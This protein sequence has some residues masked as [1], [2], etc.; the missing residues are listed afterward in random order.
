M[1]E[2]IE[3]FNQMLMDIDRKRIPVGLYHGEMGLCIYFY[4]VA[5]LTSEKKY[6]DFADRLLDDVIN[7]VDENSAIEIENGLTGICMGINYLL[8]KGYTKGNP[9]HVLKNFDDKI[10]KTLLFNLIYEK[11]MTLPAIHILTG[12]LIYLAVRLQNIKLSKDERWIM[13]NLIIENINKIE[14]CEIEKFTEPVFFSLADYFTPLYLRLLQQISQLHF[15]D[16]KIEKIVEGLS[17]PLLYRYPL[18]KANRLLL[19]SAMNDVAATFSGI[20]GWKEHIEVLQHRLDIPSVVHEFRN[21]NIAFFNGL[22]GLYYLLR[23]TGM[24]NEYNDLF[25]SKITRSDIWDQALASDDALQSSISLYG[26]LP[27]VILTYLHILHPNDPVVFFDHVIGQY[28]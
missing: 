26:G 7:S 2:R 18:N 4:E 12:K 20:K 9:N 25:L 17:A 27:G 23:K 15:Y 19:C 1:Q 24:G 8:E 5:R 10:M 6:S 16:Y 14:S 28:V 11:N 13:Q 21:K 22:C 3:K